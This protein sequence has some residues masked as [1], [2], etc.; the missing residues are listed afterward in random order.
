MTNGRDRFDIYVKEN[1]PSLLRAA[2]LLAGEPDQAEDLVQETLLKVWVRWSRISRT[3]NPA[4]YGYRTLVNVHISSRRRKWWKEIP[5][6]E[7]RQKPQTHARLEEVPQRMEMLDALQA[8]PPRQRA[9]IVLRYFL[10]MT[11]T[12]VATSMGCT[13]GTVKSQS[14]KAMATLRTAYIAAS[15]GGATEEEN[16]AAR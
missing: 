5:S 7:L 6:A 8:L 14:S 11:E 16:D 9:I 4:G 2:V 1:Y 15:S 10:D 12:Q 3:L 13:A